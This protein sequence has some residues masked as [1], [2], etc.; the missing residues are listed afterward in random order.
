MKWTPKEEEMLK[1]MCAADKKVEEIR[2]VFPYRTIESLKNKAFNMN[3]SM[4][5]ERPA[6]DLDAFARIMGGKAK[7]L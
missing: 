2:K 7:C 6:P 4:A 3:L 1:K 5:G